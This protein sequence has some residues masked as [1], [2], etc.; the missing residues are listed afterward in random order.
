MRFPV[1][2]QARTPGDD[3]WAARPVLAF[4]VRGCIATVPIVASLATT[5]VARAV[6]PMPGPAGTRVVW[7]LG[8]L[9]V[10]LLTAIG[11]E[12][13]MRKAM[14]I[15]TLLRMA[16]LFPDRAPSRFQ[17]ARRA[18]SA[19]RLREL[20]DESVAA[21]AGERSAAQAAASV[22]ALVTALSAHDRRTRGHAER[23]RIFTDML[24]EEFTLAEDER[25]RLRWAALLH[26]IGK[27]TVTSRILNKPGRLDAAEWEIMSAHPLEG[28]RIAE[29]LMVWLGPWGR[30]IAEHHERFDGTGYPRGRAGD[31]I[32]VGARMVS[33]ADAYDTMT[34]AR[35]YKRPMATRAARG[36]LARCAGTQ[37]DPVMVRAFLSIS[38]PRLV[39][40]SGPGSFL[41][42]LP[43]LWQV[44]RAG[45]QAAGVVA[46]AAAAGVV[47]TAAAVTMAGP[48]S[49]VAHHA[50]T[51]ANGVGGTTVVQAQPP[52]QVT[53]G[54][55]GV[56]AEPPGGGHGP[57]RG[58]GGESPEPGPGPTP[59]PGDPD[60]G[61]GL[62][63]GLT[64]KL[65]VQL[66]SLPVSLPTKLPPLP[67]PL[68][69]KLP[70][71]PL[72]L[73]TK[74]PLSLPLPHPHPTSSDEEA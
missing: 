25:D 33:V 27:L 15:A 74:P 66:P 61:D 45:G 13:A 47:A 67:L 73:P 53:G 48:L 46:Q 26:D 38:V 5:M 3:R 60:G 4:L 54:R 52:G 71:L 31:A 18:W 29:P 6:F 72:P 37:F 64:Q 32:S 51:A 57:G 35:S 34:A 65:P 36:E 17:V 41:V 50:G 63:G 8:I 55:G 68:P 19:R 20:A 11:A 12:R 14:P 23:V 22:L 9:G 28:A 7:C 16:M 70:P 21:G 44:Q 1:R 30:T 62:L 56:G 39:W 40:V 58:P 43:Y 42:H 49:T 24:A 69:T 10:A 2:P 59:G